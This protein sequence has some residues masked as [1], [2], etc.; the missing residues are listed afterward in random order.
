MPRGKYKRTKRITKR[1]L[2][3]AG[4]VPGPVNVATAPTPTVAPQEELKSYNLEAPMQVKTMLI[5]ILDA[6][7]RWGAVQQTKIEFSHSCIEQCMRNVRVENP[8]K[9][10][11]VSVIEVKDSILYSVERDR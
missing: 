8:N 2:P 3:P 10:I 5:E 1:N 9:N 6:D 4:F 11:R 7:E